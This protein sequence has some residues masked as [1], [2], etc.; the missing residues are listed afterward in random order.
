V[1]EGWLDAKTYAPAATKAWLSLIS[2]I[3]KEGDMAE[4][5]EGINK[6]NDRQYYLDKKS[7]VDDLHG[8][9]PVP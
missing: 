1:K 8:K 2:C 7:N 9:A 3:N 6:K 4:V 5:C